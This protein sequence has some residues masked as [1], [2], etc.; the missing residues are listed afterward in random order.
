MSNQFKPFYIHFSR[1]V[2]KTDSSKLRHMPRGFTAYIQPSALDRHV[3]VQ[4]AFCNP[5]D[6]FSKKQGRSYAQAAKIEAINPREL[7]R[8]LS[9]A[10]ECC[11]RLSWPDE[12][13]YVLKYML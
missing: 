10:K 5:K 11:G 12:Y 13:L 8:L 1:P 2:R 6:E 3:Q 7:T 9:A 4:M